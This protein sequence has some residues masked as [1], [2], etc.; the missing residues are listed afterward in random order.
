M[1]SL[2]RILAIILAFSVV[3]FAFVSC[4]GGDSAPKSADFTLTAVDSIGKPVSNVMIKYKNGDGATKRGVTDKDG[5]VRLKNALVGEVVTLDEEGNTVE[6]ITTDVKLSAD[7]SSVRIVVRD[8]EKAL[9]VFG[10]LEEKTYAYQIDVAEYTIPGLKD[11]MAYFIFNTFQKGTYKV[12]VDSAD[13]EAT[14]GYYGIPMFVQTTHRGSGEYDGKSFELIIQDPETP[15]VIGLNFVKEIDA[16]LKI[17]RIG[18]APFDPSYAEWEE[19]KAP[20]NLEKCD[21]DGMVLESLDI[22]N[23]NLSVTLAD[24]GFYYTN[25]GKKVYVRITSDVEQGNYLEGK[26]IPIVGSLAFLAGYVDKN[27]GGNVGGYIYDESGNFVCKKRYN[28]MIKTYMEYVDDTY[29]VVALTEDLAEC[30]KL[31]GRSSG[32]WD[33]NGV[34]DVFDGIVAH[35]ENAWLIYCMA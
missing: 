15:Y 31:Q 19:V 2:V 13:T 21:T 4:R 7:E 22:A 23:R 27:V 12:T 20:E 24:D 34:G 30:I 29:G 3:S 28:D 17:E 32:W 9:E 6:L 26:F 11:T 1:K 5:K 18:D 33:E 16:K 25:T 8:P 14:V 10:E 35:P